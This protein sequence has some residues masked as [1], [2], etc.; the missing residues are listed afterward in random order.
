M[1]R[2]LRV[3]L[4][5]IVMLIVS[6]FFTAAVAS[7][8]TGGD[9]ASQA[10]ADDILDIVF[11]I[12]TS[13]SM[14]DDINAI[15]SVAESAIKNLN[16]DDCDVFVRASFLGM[17]QTYGIF[18]QT[19]ENYVTNAGG[20]PATLWYESNGTAVSEM[21]EYYNWNDDSTEAQ[22]Y[23]KAVVTIGDEGTYYGYPVTQ[24]DWDAAYQANQDA[25]NN[26]V[27]L[28]S[29]VTNDPY[30][31]VVNLFDIMATGGAGGGYT[32]GDTG[33]D[34]INDQAGSGDVQTYIEDII[35]TAAT[36]G[37][38]GQDP[39][40]P[41]PSTYVLMGSGLLGLAWYRRRQSK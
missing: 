16:C 23:Y 18:D 37:T 8:I 11:V 29:W 35:C 5:G 26:D 39:V 38:G 31:G 25:I 14:Y 6:G 33:G 1:K 12:D 21:V 28:F 41:E 34:L 32:F 7:F 10:A 2:G 9:A 40:I 22:D 19:V 30:P 4:L 3:G 20:T 24:D 36:G 17:T 13:G 15:G 27:F